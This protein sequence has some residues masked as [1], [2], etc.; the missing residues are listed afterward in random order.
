MTTPRPQT[1]CVLALLIGLVAGLA[2]AQTGSPLVRLFDTISPEAQPLPGAALASRTGWRL[3]PEHNVTHLFSGDAVML[4]NRAAVVLRRGAGGP[5]VYSR[6]PNGA[7]L[8]ATLGHARTQAGTAALLAALNVVENRSSAVALEA[9]FRG[10][11]S[12]RLGVRL[13]AGEAIIEVQPG[14]GSGFAEVRSQAAYVVVPDYFGDDVVYRTDIHSGLYLPA[15]NVCLTLG[16]SGDSILMC[17]WQSSE[18]DAWLAAAGVGR[19]W[20]NCSLR[21]A[22]AANQKTWLAVLESPGIWHSVRTDA[23]AEWAPP[24]PAKWRQSLARPDGAVGSWDFD[25]G[26]ERTHPARQAVGPCVVYPIDRSRA[27][28]LTVSCPTD[29]MRNTLGLGPCQYILAVEGLA[30]EGDATP[31]NVMTWVEK[32]FARKQER[33]AADDIGERLD[34]M[35]RHIGRAQTR[36]RQYAEAAGRLRAALGSD[37]DSLELTAILAALDGHVDRGLAAAA[38]QE[39]AR[40]LADQVLALIGQENALTACRSLGAPIRAIGG[41]QDS[42]LARCRMALRRL[43]QEARTIGTRQAQA[44][45]PTAKL[46]RLAED[47]LRRQ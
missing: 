8:R 33:K 43:R 28:P 23:D 11:D 22:C 14:A 39:Q 18:Q 25:Q 27:T 41:V 38:S 13:T 34:H 17:V 6:T 31:A 47:V 9:T 42:A 10:D 7:T 20:G 44:D 46:Q 5:E 16:S 4:N 15:E 40:R 36:I 35:V 37:A 19:K 29:V 2:Y 1:H 32:Q 21:I 45:G 3:V 26:S 30:T 24:F 12:P